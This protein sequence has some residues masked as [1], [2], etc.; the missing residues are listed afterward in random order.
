MYRLIENMLRGEL[1][2]LSRLISVVERDDPEAR[3]IMKGIHPY[4]GRA[5]LV[6]VTGPPGGGKSTLV[7]CLTRVARGKGLSVGIIAVD[8][9]SPFTGGALLLPP[10]YQFP[11]CLKIFIVPLHCLVKFLNAHIINRLSGNNRRFPLGVAAGIATKGGAGAAK[12]A[13]T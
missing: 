6:G 10:M 8:P 12:S 3:Q 9:T 7:G 1:Q 11:T 13:S 2:P 4:L 5:Y